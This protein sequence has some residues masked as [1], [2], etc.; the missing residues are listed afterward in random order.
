MRI[1]RSFPTGVLIGV[2]L[3]SLTLG[4]GLAG[5]K[6]KEKNSGKT[7]DQASGATADDVDKSGWTSL[8]PEGD[9]AKIMGEVVTNHLVQNNGTQDFYQVSEPEIA[10]LDEVNRTR[11][12]WQSELLRLEIAYRTALSQLLLGQRQ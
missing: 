1:H 8:Y 12:E 10:W 6:V 11:Q 7:T 3:M 9:L 2:L 4:S 5:A